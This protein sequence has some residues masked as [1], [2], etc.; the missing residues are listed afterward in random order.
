MKKYHFYVSH[1]DHFKV[2][3][4]AVVCC[5]ITAC[6][7]KEEAGE[8]GGVFIFARGSDAHKLDPADVDDGESVNTLAQICEGLV[9]F[10]SGTLEIEAALAESFSI[11]DEG[12]RYRFELRSGV[13]FHDGTPL[14]AATAAYSF[15][16]QMDSNHPGHL[17][18]A[19]YS[20]WNYLYQDIESVD[21]VGEMSLE[22]RLSKPNSSL[23]YSL[24]IFPAALVSP[25]ALAKYGDQVQR[26]PIGT[27]PYKFVEWRPNEAIVLERNES[28]WGER[29]HFERLI[30]KVVPDST[31]RTLQLKSGEIHGM[32]GVRPSDLKN[33][34]DDASVNLYRETGLNVGYLV[35]N[36]ENERL[37]NLALRRA[38]NLAIDRDAF[39]RV[40]LNGAGT[41]AQFPLPPG[42][43]GYPESGGDFAYAP[44]E[45]RKIVDELGEGVLEAPL[46]IRVMNAPRA[47]FPDP[48][49][50]ATFIKGQLENVGIAC[51][52]VSSDFKSQLNDL[53]NGDFELGLIGWIGDNG[54]TDNF[55][56][57]FFA[58]WAAKK[59]SATN[60][61]F[62]R[63]PEMDE[64][65]L[66]ARKS[67]SSGERARLY[68][69]ALMLSDRD[70]PLVPLAH[71]DNM[72]A[73]RSGLTGFE[74]QKIGDLRLGW[75]RPE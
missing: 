45:A 68:S 15:R 39:A 9:R 64:L 74:L 20:Y 36:L 8:N 3:L 53:R 38:I 70:I 71:G 44:E 52:V 65:L 11:L 46:K 7:N 61:S 66:A 29:S 26:Y 57:T 58:S 75:I 5:L 41:A 49:V 32:D 54:D 56:S 18:E 16:R 72:I 22:I 6:S 14:T 35:F 73:L 60:Y 17:A 4:L 62:Y 48:I 69:E 13:E 21:V 50:A 12:L 47:Y 40:A 42:F 34:S 55:L 59:G 25:N 24:A 67:S 33:L 31:V 27:G 2:I 30:M 10:K 43:L 19:A 28:Y 37:Q 23:L 1:L 51:E 63:N